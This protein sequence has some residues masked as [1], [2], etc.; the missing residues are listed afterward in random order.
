VL[1]LKKIS[2]N[3]C[4]GNLFAAYGK[5]IEVDAPKAQKRF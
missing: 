5:E 1:T 2:A 3:N 4:G